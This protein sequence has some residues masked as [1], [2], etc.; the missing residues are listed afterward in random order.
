[1]TACLP[2]VLYCPRAVVAGSRGGGA[3]Y[4]RYQADADNYVSVM[5]LDNGIWVSVHRNSTVS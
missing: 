5:E 1:M 2:Y 4:D 3:Y